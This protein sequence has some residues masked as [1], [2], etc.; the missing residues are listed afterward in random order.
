MADAAWLTYT[1]KARWYA[2]LVERW[3]NAGNRAG[4]N[5]YLSR[6]AGNHHLTLLQLRIRKAAGGR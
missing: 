5:Q 6:A 3:R 1:F 2:E 4:N